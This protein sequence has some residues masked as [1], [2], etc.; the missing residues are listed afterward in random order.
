MDKKIVIGAAV[1]AGFLLYSK[2]GDKTGSG[3]KYWVPAQ[4]SP[5]GQAIQVYESELPQYGFIRY[6]GQW[7]HSSQYPPPGTSANST[8][9]NWQQWAALIQQGITS[10]MNIYTA[11]NNVVQEFQPNITITPSWDTS[12][13]SATSGSVQYVMKAGTQQKSGTANINTSMSQI[14]GNFLFDISRT[15]S[16]VITLSITK[17]DNGTVA[18]TKSV[19]FATN[20]IT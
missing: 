6:Q 5:T 4:Y 15:S 2:G 19:N 10:G 7:Y 18:A 8:T 16:S 17:V 1:L 20:T 11:V 13:Q 9:M 3:P 12:S 14:M